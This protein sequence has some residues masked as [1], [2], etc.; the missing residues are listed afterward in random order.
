[1][2]KNAKKTPTESK[3]K[4]PATA[5]AKTKGK[6]SAGKQAPAERQS[7]A[8]PSAAPE[9]AP[10]M[11]AAAPVTEPTPAPQEVFAAELA[12]EPATVSKPAA[13]PVPA[14]PPA[15]EASVPAAPEEAQTS[16]ATRRLP[17]VG[18][19]LQKRD[20]Q[21]QLRCECVVVEDG[22][23]YAGTVYRSLSAA[24][25]AATRD[26][27]LKGTQVNGFTFWGLTKPVRHG[28]DPLAALE[29]K[30]DG[31]WAAVEAALE[32]AKAGENREQALTTIDRH[33]RVLQNIRDEVA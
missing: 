21:G 8:A 7:K 29:R 31:Y 23:R 15:E 28:P 5:A 4:A 13:E 17:P 16:G 24:A 25:V 27:G 2:K 14:P 33:A 19:V 11:L 26:L 18:T 32:K 6:G 22:V 20:R 12:H 9:P 3:K 1:M 10:E 30:W